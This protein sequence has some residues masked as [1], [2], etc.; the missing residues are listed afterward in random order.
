M[1]IKRCT[2]KNAYQDRKYGKQNRVMN[3][4]RS[5]RGENTVHRCTVCLTEK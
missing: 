4:T 2:C 1:A 3:R 5:A